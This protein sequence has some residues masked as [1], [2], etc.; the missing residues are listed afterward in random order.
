MNN[1]PAIQMLLK[2]KRRNLDELK[3]ENTMLTSRIH[4]VRR[5]IEAMHKR[6]KAANKKE[7]ENQKKALKLDQQIDK[8]HSVIQTAMERV[9]EATYKA[10]RAEQSLKEQREHMEDLVLRVRE[11]EGR[12]SG[13]QEQLRRAE[14]GATG[15][16]R[17]PFWV[18]DPEEIEW[19][20]EHG[21]GTFGTGHVAMFRGL[22]VAATYVHS[23]SMVSD[24][25]Q[26][27]YSR[28]ISIAATIR[29]PNI[30]QFIG[31]TLEGYPII[32]TEL[33]ATTLKVELVKLSPDQIS[34][35]SLDVARA[36][37]YMHQMKP[38]PIIHRDVSSVNVLL[39]PGPK[40]SWLAKLSN[41]GSANY[42][43]RI[44]TQSPGNPVYAAPEANTPPQHS[45]KMDVF[46]YGVLLL[47][48]W[49]QHTPEL[50]GRQ[51]MLHGLERGDVREMVRRCLQ[52]NPTR[53]PGMADL[54]QELQ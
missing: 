46:S 37:L 3:E 2:S 1:Q 22:N 15:K 41:C 51:A 14:G 35:I 52:H 21:K 16:W 48:M 43:C 5:S 24:Y 40:D 23:D 50:K 44:L 13:L 25:N 45:T 6:E 17:R 10:Y 28:E 47:E 19:R 11:I 33:M 31:A 36:L 26:V 54:L 8:K 7:R 27:L 12:V 9:A 30:V 42:L 32:L 34:S 4:Q 39:N 29:H 53:R 20:E 18:V 49:C 38:D